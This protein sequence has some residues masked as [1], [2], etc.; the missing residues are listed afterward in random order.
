MA[1]RKRSVQIKGGKHETAE[2]HYEFMQKGKRYYGVCEG[3]TTLEGAK[4]YE[5]LFKEKVK[6]LSQQSNSKALVENFWTD[7]TGA[8]EIEVKDAYELSKKK[9]RK[10]I[11][12]TRRDAIKTSHWKDF[13]AFMTET[14]PSIKKLASVTRK[15]AEEYVCHLRENG[16]FNVDVLYTRNGHGIRTKSSGA[17]SNATLVDYQ[18]TLTEVFDLLGH[19]AG[20]IENPF[21]AIP[22]LSRDSETRDAFS[23]E[24]LKTI[25]A[26]W[27]NFTRPLFIIAMCTALREGDICT[28]RWEEVDFDKQLILRR[29]MRKTGVPVEIP[30]MPPLMELLKELFTNRSSGTEGAYSMFVLPDHARMYQENASGISYRIKQF[31]EKQCKIVTTRIPSGRKRAVSVKD[32]HSCRHTF[33]YIAGLIGIPLNVVQSIVGHMTQEMTAHYS[34][35]VTREAKREKMA[36]MPDVFC[37]RKNNVPR[38]LFLTQQVE[39]EREELQKLISVLDSGTIKSILQKLK[40]ELNHGYI[41][42]QTSAP[43]N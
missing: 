3:C 12:G 31:L 18:T 9:P 10:R 23:E 7:L 25:A 11:P 6:Q 37:L 32:L 15:H 8:C 2:Y 4:K 21:S 5:H 28:L 22:K 38:E 41:A 42:K 30:I 35:H 16:R 1:V 14:Y 26:N 40:E 43:N 24:E 33:C 39:P 36:M 17:L 34:A 29:K 19:D 13:S 20:V 27:D